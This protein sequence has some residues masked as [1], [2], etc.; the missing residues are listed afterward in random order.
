MLKFLH[1]PMCPDKS[2][3]SSEISIINV[4]PDLMAATVLSLYGLVGKWCTRGRRRA[5]SIFWKLTGG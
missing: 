4:M 5:Y 3:E 1:E 2:K